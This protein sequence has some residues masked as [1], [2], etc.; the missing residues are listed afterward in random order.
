MVRKRQIKQYG[1][2][3]A[4]KLEPADMKDF[5]IVVGDNVIIDDII[6]STDEVLDP[7]EV[8]EDQ[9]SAIA[10]SKLDRRKNETKTN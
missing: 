3:R 9:L 10:S 7:K 8:A 6:K 4:I 1:N 2:S 5:N